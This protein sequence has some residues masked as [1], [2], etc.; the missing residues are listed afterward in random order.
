MRRHLT[1]VVAV[2]LLT[3]ACSTG[4]GNT[5]ST[6]AET[7]DVTT[8][9][10]APAGSTTTS[11]EPEMATPIDELLGKG[12]SRYPELGNGGYDVDHYTVDLTFD[13]EP[14]TINALVTIDAT[15]T[16]AIQRFSLD[17]SGF[18]IT[19]LEVDSHP[20]TFERQ[21]D[22]LVIDAGTVIPTGEAFSV[23][24]AY[25]GNPEPVLSQALPFY[26]GW[27]TDSNGT[28]YVVSEPDGAHT[29]MPVNDHPSDKA[30]YTFKITVPDPL[31]AAANGSHTDTITDLGW[32]TWVWEMEYPM[33][34]YLAT[35]VVGSLELV[36]DTS[37]SGLAGVDVRNVLPG[38]LS[39]GT[40]NTLGL[41]GEMIEYL[42]D[43]FGPYPFDSYGLAVV[44]DFEAALENQTLSIFGRY[45]VDNPA[46]FESVMVHE[47]AHQW[48]GDSIS[49]GDWGDVWLNEGFATYAEWLWIEHTRGRSAM[50][51]TISGARSQMALSTDAP[52]GDPPADDLFNSSVYL[53]GGLVLHALRAEVG[54]DIFFSILR[55]YAE[56][57]RNG[58]ATTDDFIAL[59]EEISGRDLSG[60]FENW[61]YGEEIPPLP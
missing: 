4:G 9:T 60:L 29:W 28:S 31:V 27:L 54:D 2:L 52:P 61:L 42:S 19:K 39:P 40:L 8:S 5:G 22:K 35:V 56:R 11:T 53:R 47:L 55:T 12:D 57:F 25:Q 48:F 10:E 43:T 58:V 17:F 41:H 46:F 34:S 3:A 45:M 50:L 20:A 32:S 49:V 23:A 37:A 13:P 18:D 6:A 21:D 14:K 33:A 15:A 59:A 16:L 44:D 30:T 36:P 7:P 24:V 26:I 51:A 38:D 1:T